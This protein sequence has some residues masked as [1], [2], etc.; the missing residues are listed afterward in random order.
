M[1]TEFGVWSVV[2]GVAFVVWLVWVSRDDTT[3]GEDATQRRTLRR[4][5]RAVERRLAAMKSGERDKAAGLARQL[6]PQDG[7]DLALLAA[8][9]ADVRD[10]ARRFGLDLDDP[11]LALAARAD[12]LRCLAVLVAQREARGEM[13]HAAAAG[14]WLYTLRA[15]ENPELRQSMR[16]VWAQVA[17]GYSH[18]RDRDRLSRELGVNAGAPLPEWRPPRG[19]DP[20]PRD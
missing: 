17:R 9:L 20:T 8:C 19:F 15:I 18:W 2:I 3:T 6:A 16:D 11:A 14:V 7:E 13:L 10:E 1:L 4:G 5:L 12:A